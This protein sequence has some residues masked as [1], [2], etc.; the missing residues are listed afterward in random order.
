MVQLKRNLP[1]LEVGQVDNTYWAIEGKNYYRIDYTPT[2]LTADEIKFRADREERGL[3]N[4]RMC[5]VRELQGFLQTRGVPTKGRRTKRDLIDVLDNADDEATFTRFI[6]LPAELRSII[7]GKHFDALP[8]LPLLPHQPPLTLASSFIR[9]E[10]LP[11]Y[12]TNCTFS[13]QFHT[14]IR[15]NMGP[16]RV[17]KRTQKHDA[18]ASLVRLMDDLA[19]S[20]I[21]RLELQL[22]KPE[23]KY[24]RRGHGYILAEEPEPVATWRVNLDENIGPATEDF[25]KHHGTWPPPERMYAARQA[26]EEVLDEI[27]ARSGTH[28][29]LKDDCKSFMQ[30]MHVATSR[31]LS[32]KYLG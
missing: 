10:C 4:Y 8:V 21:R 2:A 9:A 32:A 13:L 16:G 29:L 22:M 11:L 14:E 20:R 5:R 25:E 24:R 17:Q 26:L 30:A 23:T 28:K 1:F 12:Y 3:L 7:Y 19:F 15:V 18:S 6:D 27:R 31:Q